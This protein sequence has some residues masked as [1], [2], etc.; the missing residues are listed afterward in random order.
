MPNDISQN[1]DGGPF[2]RLSLWTVQLRPEIYIANRIPSTRQMQRL[3]QE[4]SISLRGWTFP[5]VGRVPSAVWTNFEGG[6]QLYFRASGQRPEAL[7]VYKSGLVVWSS[8]VGEDTW[9]GLPARTRFH[10]LRSSTR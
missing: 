10:S 5:I 7:R 3:V 9:Q 6:C 4:S 1:F 8:G 2:A